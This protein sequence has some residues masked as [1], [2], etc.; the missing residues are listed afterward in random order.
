MVAYLISATVASNLFTFKLSISASLAVKV[1]FIVT[2]SAFKSLMSA[3]LAVKVSFI[4]TL[5]ACR[6]SIL[7]FSASNSPVLTLSATIISNSDI[8]PPSSFTSLSLADGE[9]IFPVTIAVWFLMVTITRSPSFTTAV[10]DTGVNCSEP[11]SLTYSVPLYLT[12]VPYTVVSFF[13]SC[14]SLVILTN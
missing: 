11:S 12:M 14:V 9:D 8:L 5:S 1:S 6:L 10:D 2:L 4:V 3:S 7:A 13:E